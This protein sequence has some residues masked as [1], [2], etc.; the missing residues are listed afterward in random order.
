[1]MPRA[2]LSVGEGRGHP[3]PR[4]NDDRSTN[5]DRFG[6][7]DIQKYSTRSSVVAIIA[8]LVI[9]GVVYFLFR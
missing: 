3:M 7:Q 9:L 4:Q 5:E 8:I 6:R 2:A 1:M